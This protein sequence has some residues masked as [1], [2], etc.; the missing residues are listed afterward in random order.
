MLSFKFRSFRFE[1]KHEFGYDYEILS[2]QI[3]YYKLVVLCFAQHIS[4]T[5]DKTMQ[6]Q[7][8]SCSGIL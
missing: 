4:R 2:L 5:T 7:L 6:G 3:F 1:Y 8:L